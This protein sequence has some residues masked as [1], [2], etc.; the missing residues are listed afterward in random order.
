MVCPA[1]VSGRES[2]GQVFGQPLIQANAVQMTATCRPVA[3]VLWSAVNCHTFSTTEVTAN[4]GLASENAGRPLALVTAICRAPSAKAR[5]DALI[6]GHS[7]T[8]GSTDVTAILLGRTALLSPR[9]AGAQ[10]L[11]VLSSAMEGGGLIQAV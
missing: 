7:V 11:A 4:C 5:R 6:I 1:A 10:L 9:L 3:A 8:L 2:H